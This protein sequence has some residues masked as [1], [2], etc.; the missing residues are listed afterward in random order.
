MR[1]CSAIGL[2][3]SGWPCMNRSLCRHRRWAAAG[4]P[5]HPGGR[6]SQRHLTHL[7]PPRLR[8]PSALSTTSV[9]LQ[10]ATRKAA[11]RRVC[12]E[13][14]WSYHTAV[15]SLFRL[16]CL[17]AA[18]RPCTG[19]QRN[20]DRLR[21]ELKRPEFFCPADSRPTARRQ[22]LVCLAQRRPWSGDGDVC[23]RAADT[24]YR[25]GGK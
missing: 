17:E 5:V 18:A 6:H 1:N 12:A 8:W 23:A 22:V 3:R 20:F 9:A 11:T 10:A 7:R 4:L 2:C 19:W 13:M 14:I 15:R 21:P 25:F 16:I 24:G